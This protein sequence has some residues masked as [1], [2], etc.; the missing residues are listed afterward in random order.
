MLNADRHSPS[1]R[2]VYIH[3]AI[4]VIAVCALPISAKAENACKGTV[5]LTFDTGHMGVASLVAEVLHRQG[6]QATF[7]AADEHTQTGGSSLDE[8]WASWWRARVAEGHEFASHTLHHVYWRGDAGTARQP[9]FKVRPTAGPQAGQNLTLTA[10]QYCAQIDAATQR[11]RTITGKEP[12]PMFRA[13]GG[14]TS[15]RLLRVAQSCGYHHVGWTPAG[16]LG[17]ELPSE[18]YSNAQLLQQALRAIHDG[19]VLLAHLGIWSRKDPWAP[20]VLEPLIQGLK[21]RGLCFRTLREHPRFQA[22]L[23]SD[24][25]ARSGSGRR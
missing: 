13:P 12:L 15:P 14:K 25:A 16:F 9:S 8:H 5:Y 1:S 2:R 18:R 4:Y 17:D 21:E 23:T 11:L 22:G 3:F 20:A 24:D 6:V 10:A 7:F 19:D